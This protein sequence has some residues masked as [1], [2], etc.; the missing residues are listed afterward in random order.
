MKKKHFCGLLV[1][2][3]A[4]TYPVSAMQDYPIQPV[5]FTDV[6]II[7]EFWADRIETNRSV[8][9]PTSFQKCEESGRMDNFERAARVLKGDESLTDRQVRGLSFDDTDPYKVLEGASFGLSVKSEPEM[10]KYLDDLI[11]LIASAQEAD[12]YLYTARTINPEQPHEWAGSKRWQNVKRLSHELY[13]MGHLY[14]AAAAHYL[15]T[16]KKTLLN[17][18]IKNANLLCNTFGPG[19]NLDAPG[20]QIIEMGLVKLYRVTGEKKYLD[21]AKFFLDTRGPGDGEYSQAHKKVVDQDEAVGHAV[22][23]TYMYSGMADVA[24]ITGNTSYLNAIDKIWENIVNK[25]MYVTGGIGATG[26]GEAFGRNYELPNMTAYCETCAAIGHV[27]LNQRLFLLHGQ[28]KYIDVMERI[29]YNGLISGVSLDGQTFFYP[30]P[31]E[32]IGQ[33]S[34]SPWFG[35][36]CCPGNIARFIASVPGYM[37][38]IREDNLYL[39]LFA[40]GNATVTVNGNKVEIVQETDYPWKGNIKL[41]IKPETGTVPF[42]FHVRIP[43]WARNECVPGDLYSF[44]HECSECPEV[45]LNGRIVPD[46]LIDGYISITRSWKNGDTVE[47]ELPMPVRRVVA[48]RKVEADQGMVAVQRGPIMYCAE[49]PDNPDGHVRNLILS[50]EQELVAQW[51]EDFIAHRNMMLISG[52]ADAANKDEAGEVVKTK[53]Q[54]LLIPYYAWA[55]RGRGEMAVWLAYRDE[56]VRPLPGPTIASKSKLSASAGKGS[57]K[58][59]VDQA[60]PKNSSDQSMGIYHWWPDNNCTKWIMMEFEKPATVSGTEVYWFDDRPHGGCRVPV[61]WRLL[62]RDG[63]TWR[64]VKDGNGYGVERNI[65]N[66]TA[67]EA[68]ATDALKIELQLS[69]RFS[70]GILEWRVD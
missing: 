65:Y 7:G 3:F 28:A 58:V 44:L 69:E 24:A 56:A 33:H 27:Y 66:Q 25:K 52:E 18:A 16:G 9:I 38:A 37:Y 5:S 51:R 1:A 50:D 17:I 13:N 31:L 49:W 41:T 4:F 43:G 55:H 47:L 36:A 42:N 59:I 11:A 14:E 53:Q 54:L 10:D 61:S 20:H 60:D 67:F 19:K 29:L 12:G 15:A 68:V 2:L 40:A 62:Y 57:L 63:D 22:R 48:N 64:Q 32:S 6:T 26:S 70:G 30:N 39:N 23:A 45:K 21:L 8:T 46:N 35:C 34:R